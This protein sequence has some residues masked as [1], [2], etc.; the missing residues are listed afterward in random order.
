MT[1]LEKMQ[2]KLEGQER[3]AH[4]GPDKV[5]PTLNLKSGDKIMDFGSGTGLYAIAMTQRMG[6]EVLA[7]DISPQMRQFLSERA[8]GL[9]ITNL[10]VSDYEAVSKDI[11][12]FNHIVASLVLHEVPQLETLLNHFYH[13]L[14]EG[15]KITIV[16]ID[17]AMT[18]LTPPHP[19]LDRQK[20]THLLHL[21]GFTLIDHLFTSDIY[22]GL[23]ARK[24]G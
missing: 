22:Y 16:E 5:L 11:P 14:F 19:R 18:G 2:S 23:S 24:E 15:G 21:A 8:L 17:E 1:F 6:T 13:Q 10:M 12:Q 20:L 3:M 4:I 7:V 9:G